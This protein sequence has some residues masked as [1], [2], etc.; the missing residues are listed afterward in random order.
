MSEYSHDFIYIVYVVLWLCYALLG[1]SHD[2]DTH[3]SLLQINWC[4]TH[5]GRYSLIPVCHMTCIGRSTILRNRFELDLGK[6]ILNRSHSVT[7][8]SVTQEWLTK[9][10]WNT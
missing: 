8:I 10:P 9:P 2:H 1:L 4:F 3:F 6:E 5:F 7:F